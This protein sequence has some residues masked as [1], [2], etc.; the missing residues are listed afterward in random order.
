MSNEGPN[1]EHLNFESIQI[2]WGS[3]IQPFEIWKHMK[4]D[5]H[6]AEHFRNFGFDWLWWPFCQNAFEN[7]TFLLVLEYSGGSNTEHSNTEPI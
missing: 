3:E 7:Q 2:Q 5:P 6:C 4:S 1:T